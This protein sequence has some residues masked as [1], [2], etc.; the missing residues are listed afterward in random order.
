VK[1]Y[2][3]LK[4]LNL[5]SSASSDSEL[6]KDD[7]ADLEEEA[8]LYERER[9][10][11]DWPYRANQMKKEYRSTKGQKE[12]K[13]LEKKRLGRAIFGSRQSAT[14]LVR[15]PGSDQPERFLPQAPA[16]A[17]LAPRLRGGQDARVRVWNTEASSFWDRRQ[18]ESF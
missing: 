4:D 5:S 8:A 9:Y 12:R 1:I 13:K 14:F 10:D 3:S 7:E 18:P 6:S 2:P 16:G 15:A 11:L 17:S